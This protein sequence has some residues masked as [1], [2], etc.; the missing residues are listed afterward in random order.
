MRERLYHFEVGF[1]KDFER[2]EQRV[3]VNYGPHARR[4]AFQDRY[5]AIKLPSFLTLRRF[6]VIEIGM[7]G[8]SVS[9][10]LFR[11]TLDDKRDLCIVLIPNGNKP[12]RA[13][14]VWVNLRTD[15]HKT[16]NV[17]RYEKVA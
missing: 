14:T 13:K 6:Q 11:G 8:E 9:K 4:E 16:L 12:W 10:I 2:P 1:P 17:S 5:G 3:K 15:K 7:V